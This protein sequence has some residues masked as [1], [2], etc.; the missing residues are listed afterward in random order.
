MLEQYKKQT[1]KFIHHLNN[2]G[3]V[4][5]VTHDY[6]DPDC[7]ASAL[8]MSHLLKHFNIKNSLITFG[9]FVGRAENRALIRFVGINTVPLMLVDTQEYDRI[10]L[11]DCFPKVGNLSLNK[12]IKVD[13]VFDHH[14]HPPCTDSSIFCDLRK[15]LGATSTLI[16]QYLRA[17]DIDIGPDLATALFYGIK[18]D[19]ND[20]ARF[21]SVEDLECYKLLFDLMDHRLLS[22]I[23]S[24]DREIEYFKVLHRATE[25]MVRYDNVG[26]T[27]I[28][29][30]S[31]PDHVAE[32]A[33]LFHSLESVEQMICT[34]IFKN[35][36]FYSVRS[37][38]SET[39]GNIAE[40]IAHHLNGNGGGH[41]TMAAGRIP[42]P[43]GLHDLTLDRFLT[44]MKKVLNIENVPFQKI[45]TQ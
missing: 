26:Y 18:T 1:E 3:S 16:T 7:I 2:P 45:L 22:K 5:I 20:M 9:G 32:I 13:A 37:K 25:S 34:G 11:V 4:L 31:T 12:N 41:S 39:A 30:V 23:E 33:D 10:I 43:K 44:T 35:Q 40:K 15:D 17:S 38:R 28:G 24:P 19:T 36:I 42:I 6:P 27:H 8:G 14:P 29:I 21:S